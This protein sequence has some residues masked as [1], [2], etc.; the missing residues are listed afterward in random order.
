MI[1][2]E[3]ANATPLRRCS[4]VCI[5]TLRNANPDPRSTIPKTAIPSGMYSVV[6]IAANA[7][8]N[9]D[10]RMTRQKI[11]Q[12]WLASHTGPMAR[13]I[14][15]RARAPRAAPPAVRSHRPTPKSAPPNT[16]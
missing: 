11:S 10:H 7:V 15:A 13:S 3:D 12:V 5:D 6:M 4:A 8:G 9:P 1:T 2:E 14:S 16:P